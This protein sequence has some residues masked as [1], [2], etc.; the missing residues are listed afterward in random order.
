MAGTARVNFTLPS[1]PGGEARLDGIA[2][3]LIDALPAHMRRGA[4]LVV[5]Q[6]WDGTPLLWT[7]LRCGESR[8]AHL[9]WAPASLP[10]EEVRR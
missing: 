10:F 4:V 6:D 3:E 1:Y 7:S 8:P 9:F 2:A 5:A